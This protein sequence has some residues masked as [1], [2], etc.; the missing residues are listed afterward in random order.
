MQSERDKEDAEEEE[1]HR[2]AME[3]EDTCYLPYYA[4]HMGQIMGKYGGS[5]PLGQ[6]CEEG[7]DT[8]EQHVR[9]YLQRY[10][11]GRTPILNSKLAASPHG[12]IH[13]IIHCPNVMVVGEQ[14]EAWQGAT[15]G[16]LAA[17]SNDD[18]RRRKLWLRMMTRPS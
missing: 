1:A 10:F 4:Q 6:L 8:V 5:H 14:E 11:L 2:V 7:V 16:I 3:S 15:D 17:L 18:G 12:I 13:D 9:T